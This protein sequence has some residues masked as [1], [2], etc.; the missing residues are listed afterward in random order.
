MLRRTGLIAFL[1]LPAPAWAQGDASDADRAASAEGTAQTDTTADA[2]VETAAPT[3]AGS[4]EPA[5]TVV[6]PTAEEEVVADAAPPVDLEELEAFKATVSRY[7]DR[8]TEFEQD[9]RKYVARREVEERT[10]LDGSY[11]VVIDELEADDKALRTTAM[12]RFEA[13]LDK[14]PSS[15]DAAHVMF[16]LA[17]LYFERAEEDYAAR[18]EEFRRVMDEMTETGNLDEIPEEPKKD[19][20]KSVRLYQRILR[21]HPD[22]EFLD[23]T[24]YMLGYCLSE[25]AS[26]QH[27]EEEGLAMFQALVDRFSESRFAAVAHLRVGEYYFD[28]NK[29]DEAMPHYQRVVELE[30]PEGSLYDEGLYKLAW[31][32]YKKSEYDTALGLLNGLLDWSSANYERT[33]RESAMA[34]E[35]IEYTAISFSD[36]A[37][38]KGIPPIAVAQQFYLDIGQREFEP[39]VYKRLADVLVQQARYEDAVA[40]YTY[41][42]DRWP[43]DAE[44][45]NYQWQL[46][47]LYMS[48]VPP[49]ADLAQKAIA[50]LN[51]RY[52]DDSDWFQA[53]RA[54]PDAQAVARGYIEKSLAAVAT[55]LHGKAAETGAPSDYLKA[56]ELYSQYLAKFPFARDYYEIQ[57]YL[58]E[59]MLLGGNMDGAEREYTQLYKAGEHNFK[60]GS[61]WKLRAIYSQRLQDTYGGIDKLPSDALVDKSIDLPSGKVRKVYKLGAMHEAF[62]NLSDA[63]AEA[64]FAAGVARVDAQLVEVDSEL[65]RTSDPEEKKRLGEHKS[66]LEYVRDSVL[67]PYSDGLE[68]YRHAIA[69][70][71]AQILFAHGQFEGARPRLE[72]IAKEYQFTREGAFSAKTLIDTYSDEEDYANV[73]TWASHFAGRPMGPERKVDEDLGT[74]EQQAALKQ[75]EQLVQDDK[76]AEAA[77]GYLLFIEDY[78]GADPKLLKNALYNAANNYQIVGRIDESNRLFEQYVNKYPA[79]DAS[80]PIFFRLAGNYAQSLELDQAIRYYE[81]LYNNTNAAGKPYGDAPAA[82]FN[83]GFLRVGVGDFEGA[84]KNYERYQKENPEQPDAEDVFWMAAEQWERIDPARAQRFYKEYLR[85]YPEQAPDHVMEAYYRI[86]LAAEER[87]RARETE[88]AW[89]NLASTYAELAPSGKVGPVGRKY[90]GIAELRNVLADLEAFKTIPE[91]A[92]KNGDKYTSLMVAKKHELPELELRALALIKTYAEFESTSAALYTLGTAFYA[93]ADMLFNAPLPQ[94]ALD[95]PEM[96]SIYIEEIDKLRIPLEDRGRRRLTA[97]LSTAKEQGLWCEWQTRTLEELSRR[98]PAEYAP[99][100]RQFPAAGESLFVPR[101]GPLSM[102]KPAAEG[103]EGD[104]APGGDSKPETE[105][106]TAPKPAPA[107]S[108]APA[109][110]GGAQ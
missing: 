63:L 23:G 79:D 40:V 107:P 59:T 15:G 86:A 66:S 32:R 38:R 30:G 20:K 67:T 101:G 64:D 104:G 29:L 55:Q 91:S 49:R 54:N 110:G 47:T 25:P 62:L 94:A 18:D 58:A 36:M 8:M 75:I 9:A 2:P 22:Y 41:I 70:Q 96:E 99:E 57:W 10:Q 21:D 11:D 103:A 44:N 13:F 48:M 19:Y 56:S 95:D 31:S 16:R 89:A 98:I 74:L 60:E 42:Q 7:S 88:S 14:Y 34:P 105:S 81:T 52:N 80:R 109:P 46:G 85:K 33:G 50:D 93:Y 100:K 97:V 90:A 84:A 106:G 69:Y 43:N 53:N 3:A 77:D 76:R 37:D 1:L 26:A 68:R 6:D 61:L 108:P 45:P 24:Y 78:P 92:K 39:K 82:L 71:S 65:R 83:A 17:E 87:G 102:P 12:K 73:R 28:Y 4:P 5:H 35:A 27:D 51:E 72:A